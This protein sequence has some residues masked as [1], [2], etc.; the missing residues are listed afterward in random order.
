M[1]HEFYKAG[2]Y[3]PY[4]NWNF[5]NT[6]KIAYKTSWSFKFIERNIK[7]TFFFLFYLL[8]K[9]TSLKKSYDSDH[10]FLRLFY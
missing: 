2:I 4:F 3:I 1:T 6:C 10:R 7:L 8:L 9:K 5:L